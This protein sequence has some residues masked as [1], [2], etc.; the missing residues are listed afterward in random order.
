MLINYDNINRG[1]EVLE[2]DSLPKI[3][4]S[5]G[6]DCIEISDKNKSILRSYYKKDYKLLETIKI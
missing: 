5:K 1:L 3:N 6:S 2:I 4:Q